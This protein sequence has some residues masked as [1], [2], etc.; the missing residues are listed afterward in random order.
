MAAAQKANDDQIPMTR[1]GYDL[2]KKELIS[3]RTEGRSEISRKLEE[4]RAFGDLSE[5][6]E[7]HAAQ[8]EQAQLE[9]RILWLE[10]RLSKAKIVD[11]ADV[12]ASKVALGTTVT[13]L[14]LDTQAR[15]S[16]VIVSS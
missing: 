4:A 1:E 6:A 5:N 8:E 16:Y 2:L 12:D 15:Y 7:F 14:D 11:M 9:T 10:T 13:I 3:L